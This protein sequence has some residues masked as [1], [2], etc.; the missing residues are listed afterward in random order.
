M[1]K[2][3][4]MM[5]KK[6]LLGPLLGRHHGVP[7][8]SKSAGAFYDVNA[9]VVTIPSLVGLTQVAATARLI[10]VGLTLGTVTGTVDPVASQS[11]VATTIVAVGSAVNI[12][13]TA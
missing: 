11:P 3:L 7:R 12:T 1:Y 2:P 9:E 5:K 8:L 13:L 10:G 4:L 6:G